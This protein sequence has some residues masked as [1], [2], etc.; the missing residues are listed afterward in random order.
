MARYLDTGLSS[1]PDV[2]PEIQ[3]SKPST[4]PARSSY[5]DGVQVLPKLITL[6]T[7]CPRAGDNKEQRHNVRTSWLPC[8]LFRGLPPCR[9]T[10]DALHDIPESPNATLPR[11]SFHK[12]PRLHINLA[13]GLATKMQCKTGN[14]WHSSLLR[15]WHPTRN[16]CAFMISLAHCASPPRRN[17][18]PQLW[19][20]DWPQCVPVDAAFRACTLRLGVILMGLA[21][22]NTHCIDLLRPQITGE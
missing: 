13:P 3:P 20:E 12:A 6:E 4:V 21:M 5:L 2:S 22:V 9:S 19:T 17:D 1:G 14:K 18:H 7:S 11:V 8:L 10:R 15:K 16:P